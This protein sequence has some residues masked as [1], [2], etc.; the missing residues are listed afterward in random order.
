MDMSDIQQAI[1]AVKNWV[2]LMEYL[3][4]AT[5][6]LLIIIAVVSCARLYIAIKEM[7]K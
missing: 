6:G 5:V 1:D 2:H 7:S 3:G 4:F